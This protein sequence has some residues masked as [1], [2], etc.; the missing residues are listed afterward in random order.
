MAKRTCDRCGNSREL[1]GGKTC[2]RGHFICRS[3]AYHVSSSCSL[4]G[5]KLK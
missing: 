2:E 5:T 4:C 3:C 1:K